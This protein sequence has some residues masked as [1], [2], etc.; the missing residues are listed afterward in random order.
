MVLQNPGGPYFSK[1]HDFKNLG[2][3]LNYE[4]TIFLPEVLEKDVITI[5]TLKT[6]LKKRKDF[7]LGIS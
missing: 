2:F 1:K 3:F 5:F 6:F 4:P 7:P